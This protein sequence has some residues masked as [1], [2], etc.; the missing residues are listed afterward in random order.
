MEGPEEL[1]EALTREHPLTD[2][3]RTDA[4][5]DA[6][7]RGPDPIRSSCAERWDSSKEQAI[8][9]LW[10]DEGVHDFRPTII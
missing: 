6:V 2:L 4:L 9:D 10:S 7:G 1:T 5:P 3:P 8:S